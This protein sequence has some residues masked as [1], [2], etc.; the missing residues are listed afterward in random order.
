MQGDAVQF[1][2]EDSLLYPGAVVLAVYL[3]AVWQRRREARRDVPLSEARA[4][5][6]R[7][8]GWRYNGNYDG[9][10]RYRFFGPGP[11]GRSWELRYDSD[12]SSSASVPKIIW[13]ITTLAALRK[14]FEISSGKAFS[15]MQNP[16]AH[17]VSA[18]LGLL[19]QAVGASAN[20]GL[21]FAREAQVQSVG[22]GRFR[23]KWKAIGRS[24]RDVSCLLDA[25]TEAL[26]LNWPR[27]AETKFDPF[28]DVKVVRDDKGLRIEFKYDTSDVPL[29]EHVV[30]LGVALA[31]RLPPL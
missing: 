4:Q 12:A 15:R 13:E 6:A 31:A 2:I 3:L 5:R 22:S 1:H 7:Q 28:R 16:L 30:K 24:A 8:L 19:A 26:L 27:A 14:E 9:D 20:Q 11:Q 29:F 23:L 17:G 18:G 25:E 21:D 10:I